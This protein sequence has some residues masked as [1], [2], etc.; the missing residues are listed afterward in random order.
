MKSVVQK[1]IYIG[2]FSI[3]NA[4]FAENWTSYKNILLSLGSTIGQTWV[5][6]IYN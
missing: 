4:T 5:G 6:Y 1:H 3:Q 2:A